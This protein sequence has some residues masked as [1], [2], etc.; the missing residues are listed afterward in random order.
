MYSNILFF[1]LLQ[2]LKEN[3]Q[4]RLFPTIV[5]IAFYI[6]Q[7]NSHHRNLNQSWRKFYPLK[8]TK[9]NI[10]CPLYDHSVFAL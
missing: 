4:Y 3:P 1:N 6:L 2:Q 8:F 5:S 9:L 10:N 7:K